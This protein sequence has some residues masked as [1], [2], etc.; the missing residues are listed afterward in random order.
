MVQLKIKSPGDVLFAPLLNFDIDAVIPY[1]PDPET[2]PLCLSHLTRRAISFYA[3]HR[4][5]KEKWD[6]K[7]TIPISRKFYKDGKPL[8][9]LLRAFLE[10][11]EYIFLY[12]DD[13]GYA[14]VLEWFLWASLD[15]EKLHFLLPDRTKAGKA[16]SFR[17]IIHA[18]ENSQNPFSWEEYPALYRL[19]EVLSLIQTQSRHSK[20]CRKYLRRNG[21]ND[22]PPGLLV[23]LRTLANRMDKDSDIRVEWVDSGSI[24]STTGSGGRVT[25]K[26]FRKSRNK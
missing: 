8:C 10:L 1:F 13:L 2:N 6:E 17:Q 9:D 11:A 23:V 4:L 14:H 25:T 24:K 22:E 3:A 5:Y 21:N 18:I 7:H 15:I 16:D 12:V 20:A 19:G 26:T